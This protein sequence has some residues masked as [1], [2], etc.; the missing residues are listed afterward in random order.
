MAPREARRRSIL[1]TE[2]F[3]AQRLQ[4]PGNYKDLQ[5]KAN[6]LLRRRN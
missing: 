1:R 5:V 6:L 2:R 3:G 4:L